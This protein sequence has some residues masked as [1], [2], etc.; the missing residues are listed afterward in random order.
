VTDE[1]PTLEGSCLCG[2]IRFRVRGPYTE[3]EVCH[4]SLCRKLSGGGFTTTIATYADNLEWLQR[5]A[6]ITSYYHSEIYTPNFCSTCGSPV[7]LVGK[8]GYCFI[9]AG[10]LDTN[11][12]IGV[13]KHLFAGSKAEW[14]EISDDAPGMRHSH[15]RQFSLPQARMRTGSSRMP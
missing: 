2:A 10:A 8:A 11:V 1:W 5:E 4:C 15:R 13:S 7:P 9:T 6:N 12:A 14:D 3:R